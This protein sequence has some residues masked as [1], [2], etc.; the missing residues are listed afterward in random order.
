MKKII[1]IKMK[2]CSGNEYDKRKGINK[3]LISLPFRIEYM[4]HC[5]IFGNVVPEADG[6]ESPKNSETRKC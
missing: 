2:Y 6:I 3:Y 4:M 1:F 5:V